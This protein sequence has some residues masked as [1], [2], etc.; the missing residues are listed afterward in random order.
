[1]EEAYESTQGYGIRSNHSSKERNGKKVMEV[2]FPKIVCSRLYK[3]MLIEILNKVAEL[4]QWIPEQASY[5]LFERKIGKLVFNASTST[6][7]TRH[8]ISVFEEP[9]SPH[10]RGKIERKFKDVVAWPVDPCEPYLFV[11]FVFGYLKEERPRDVL[12]LLFQCK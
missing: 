4:D 1:M 11:L 5:L 3:H 10:W 2:H 9:E 7:P 8:A 6:Q 12:N